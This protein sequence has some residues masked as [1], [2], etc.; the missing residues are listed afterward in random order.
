MR[1]PTIA[2]ILGAYLLFFGI[3]TVQDRM[4]GPE[5]VLDEPEIW[6]RS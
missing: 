1:W 5:V 4:S 3:L 2:A 6:Q